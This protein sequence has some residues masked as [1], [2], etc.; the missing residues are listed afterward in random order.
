[1]RTQSANYNA[2]TE[3]RTIDFEVAFGLINEE[4][5]NKVVASSPASSAR[6][7]P[8]NAVNRNYKNLSNWA[9]F[10][11]KG[12]ILG[13]GERILPTDS[14]SI[15]LGWWSEQESNGSGNFVG[16]GNDE[17]T[18]VIGIAKLGKMVLGNSSTSGSGIPYILFDFGTPTTTYGWSLY[19]DSKNM[20]WPTEIRITVYSTSGTEVFSKVYENNADKMFISQIIEDYGA[21]KIEFL[22]MNKPYRKVRLIEADFGVTQRFDKDTLVKATVTEGVDISASK[23]PSRQLTFVFDNSKKIYNMLKPDLLYDYFSSGSEIFAKVF[24]ND[25]AVSLGQFYFT[26]AKTKSNSLTAEIIANDIIMQLGSVLYSRTSGADM[27]LKNA[28]D[29]VLSGVNVERV[30]HDN[31][32]K[33]M[34]Y[35]SAVSSVSKREMIR[36]LAQAAMCTVYVNRDGQ[37]VFKRIETADDAVGEIDKDALYNYNG[38]SVSDH[39][40]KVVVTA[41]DPTTYGGVRQY[42]AGDGANVKEVSNP[43]VHDSNGT[44][45]ARWLLDCYKRRVHYKVKNRCDPAIEIGD[46]IR[47]D[48]TYGENLNAAVTGVDL[49][50]TGG[51]YANTEATI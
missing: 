35:L 5:K 24:V 47:L 37:M 6:T 46:T 48:D 41:N 38:I 30:Y 8:E 4:A 19:F 42:E 32:D 15:P 33:T 39:I 36:Y 2:F 20:I 23:L 49:V 43:C 25:E 21:V 3:T 50:Y 1:M 31:V 14:S 9:T 11:E 18:A 22:K 7:G 34:V 27:T 44:A 17:T 10:E 28:I 29:T 13:G 16:G 12:W 51:M 40:T 26:E 45:V